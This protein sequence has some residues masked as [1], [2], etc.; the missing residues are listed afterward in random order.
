MSDLKSYLGKEVN[1]VIDRPLGS[2]HPK[3]DDIIYPVNYGYIPDT[4][5]GD[6]EEADVYLL[7]VSV[8]VRDF[9]CRII[10]VVE[11]LDDVEN[12]LVGAP[13]GVDFT[14]EEIESMINF[15][16]QYFDTKIIKEV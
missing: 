13:S 16:E 4:I 7:G 12:K 1:I 15:Q 8:P 3:H 14:I 9:V 10:A 5:S 11:R 6:G 2:V